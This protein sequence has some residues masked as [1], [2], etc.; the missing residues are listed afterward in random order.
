MSMAFYQEMQD[1][2][3]ELLTEFGQGVIRYGKIIPGAG[4]V[5]NPGPSTIQWVTFKGATARG[6]SARY[7]MRSLAVGTELQV[8]IP[9]QSGAEPDMRDVI[10]IDG[11]RYKITYIDRKP[12]AGTP[13][14]YILIIKKG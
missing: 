12:A 8:V 6:V 4:T 14:A 7:V 9:V 10:E 2:A 5:D 11:V 3:T 1:I 13:V